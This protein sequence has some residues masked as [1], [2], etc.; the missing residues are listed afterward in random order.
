MQRHGHFSPYLW[1]WIIPSKS[2]EASMPVLKRSPCSENEYAA[3]ETG[4]VSSG[5]YNISDL[6]SR[7]RILWIQRFQD[8]CEM[9]SIRY[10][11]STRVTG[12]FSPPP[13]FEFLFKSF[14]FPYSTP[15]IHEK[16]AVH[17]ESESVWTIPSVHCPLHVFL[18]SILKLPRGDTIIAH[19]CH[20]PP[21]VLLRTSKTKK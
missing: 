9:P 21:D 3:Q 2:I 14:G 18:N 17:V 6:P 12:P 1:T 4:S 5:K 10:F 7:D 15:S 13:D 19:Y 8:H 20:L 11:D 16:S